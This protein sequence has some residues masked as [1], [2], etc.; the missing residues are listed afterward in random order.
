MEILSNRR[1]KCHL[2]KYITLHYRIADS[3]GKDVVSTFDKRPATLLLGSHTLAPSLEKII[4]A[5]NVGEHKTFELPP[6]KAFG[7]HNPELLQW[8]SMATVKAQSDLGE[9]YNVGDVL[10]F[11]LP[12]DISYAGSVVRIT[13]NQLLMDFNH[14]LAG[15]PLT[16]EVKI[17]G[18]L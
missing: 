4:D 7:K 2:N 6:D 13:E 11:S 8:L 16:F 14:P 10:R 18:I 12:K 9:H 1:G 5:M 15:L 17:I 3:S